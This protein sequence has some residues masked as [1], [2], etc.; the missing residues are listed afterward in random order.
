[1][2][3]PTLNYEYPEFENINGLLDAKD[4]RDLTKIIEKQMTSI[5]K[6]ILLKI[7]TEELK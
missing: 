2:S 4:D 3:L 6:L 5:W 7:R 1:M